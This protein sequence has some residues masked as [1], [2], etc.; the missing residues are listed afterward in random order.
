MLKSWEGKG[1][2]F[3]F[4]LELKINQDARLFTEE[5]HTKQ[6]VPLEGVKILLAEDNKVN[7]T[8]AKRFMNKWGIQVAEALNGKEAVEKFKK[9]KY[10]L[11]L[12]D[13]EMPEMDGPSAL[14]EIRRFNDTVPA[15]AFTAA[16]YE[17]MQ[18]DLLK[19]GFVDYIHKPFRP[20]DLHNKIA[21]LIMERRA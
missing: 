9:D 2:E 6:L 15:M 8:I 7:L 20:E 16:V 17:N 21:A 12:I 5:D 4:T 3:F 1:S 10:D 13:L 14:R 11:M 18:N 19:K